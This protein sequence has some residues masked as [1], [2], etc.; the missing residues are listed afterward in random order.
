MDVSNDTIETNQNFTASATENVSDEDNATK[1]N[2]TSG[3]ATNNNIHRLNITGPKINGIGLDIKGPVVQV[4]DLNDHDYCIYHFS[5]MFMKH[6]DWKIDEILRAVLAEY[7]WNKAP[8]MIPEA[9]A[10]ALKV[11]GDK[12]YYKDGLDLRFVEMY[13]VDNYYDLIS[14]Q[15][16]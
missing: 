15:N 2:E 5:R 10:K 13:L 9:Y 3:N 14:P 8:K 1:S 16:D 7:A 12:M 4:P 6:P 11:K